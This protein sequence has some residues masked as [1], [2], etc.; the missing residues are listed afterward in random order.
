MWI[1]NN[2]KKLSTVRV[3][4]IIMYSVHFL[5]PH[6]SS[7]LCSCWKQRFARGFYLGT[8]NLWNSLLWFVLQK[9]FTPLH[10]AAKYGN[11]KVTKLLLQKSGNPNVEGK[12]GLAP[13]HVATHYNNPEVAEVLLSNGANVHATAKVG[14][15][16]L[17]GDLLWLEIVGNNGGLL[18]SAWC[19]AASAVLCNE[20]CWMFCMLSMCYASKQKKLRNVQFI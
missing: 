2:Q 7:C 1:G 12:N 15:I 20:W 19:C 16:I 5:D 11:A 10:I 4:W 8:F 13:L 18:R 6:L 17:R 3:C 9:G 14:G